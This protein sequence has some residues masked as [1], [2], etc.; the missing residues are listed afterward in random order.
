MRSSTF[1][2]VHVVPLLARL[3]LCAAFVPMGWTKIFGS[4]P[5]SPAESARLD[6]IGWAWKPAPA[7]AAAPAAPAAP[8]AAAAGQAGERSAA[9][10]R[11]LLKVALAADAAGLP[12]PRLSAWLVAIAELVGGAL[13]LPGVFTRLWALGLVAVMGGAIWMTSLS[14]LRANPWLHDMPVDSYLKLTAQVSL[15][16]LALGVMLTGAG[17]ASVDRLIMGPP[18]GGPEA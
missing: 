1:A 7:D 10:A 18:K 12:A 11:P 15:G 2:A 4:T 14:A 16:V 17:G 6:A 9:A 8:A 5:L 3:V 13:L